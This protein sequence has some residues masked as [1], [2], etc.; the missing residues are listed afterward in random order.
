[1]VVAKLCKLELYVACCSGSPHVPPQLWLYGFCCLKHDG[2]F[3]LYSTPGRSQL[4]CTC[5]IGTPTDHVFLSP[6]YALYT[7]YVVFA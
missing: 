5:F 1:M 4:P 6:A 3:C 7:C 2:Y